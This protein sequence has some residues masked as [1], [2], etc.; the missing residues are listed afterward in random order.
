MSI[1]HMTEV[2]EDEG[3]ASQGDT[4]LML[5]IADYANHKGTCWPSVKT[6]ARRARMDPRSVQRRLVELVRNGFLLLH[7]GQGPAG[8]NLYQIVR[9]EGGDNL[10]SPPDRVPGGGDKAVSP[11]G[12]TE[13]CHQGGDKAVSPEPSLNPH[14]NPQENR[15]RDGS[16]PAPALS[17]EGWLEG[18]K[19]LDCYKHLD[20]G[21]EWQRMVVWCGENRRK[22]SRRR[23]VNWLNHCDRQVEMKEDGDPLGLPKRIFP[24]TGKEMIGACL[25]RIKEVKGEKENLRPVL[26]REAR[27][28]IEFLSGEKREGWEARV[29]EVK[30]K[31]ENYGSVLKD[32]ARSEIDRLHRRIAEIK[33]RMTE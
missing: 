2:W 15:R 13:P 29:N 20:V 26:R 32:E 1:R 16:R 23:F 7:R 11:G 12:V 30:Q 21:M 8:C 10:S 33:R 17:D 18:L 27:E 22:P 14:L 31:P 6:L 9:R 25:E 24:R 3:I 19:G 4:L 28:L 5:A